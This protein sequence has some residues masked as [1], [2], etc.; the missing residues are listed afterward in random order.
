MYCP[1]C[2][3]RNGKTDSFCA[4]CGARLSGE[5]IIERADVSRAEEE[6]RSDTGSPTFVDRLMDH[7]SW[8]DDLLHGQMVVIAARWILVSAGL[9]L[10]LWNPF[11]IG[12]LRVQIALVL[13]LA[14][15]NFYL[16]AQVLTGKAIPA[17]VVLGASIADFAVI[18]L[19]VMIQG[20]FESSVYVF[21]FPA[22]L[23]FSVAFNTQVTSALTGGLIATYAAVA[24]TTFSGD[25]GAVLV[26]RLITIA[27]VA[28]CGNLYWR[29]ERDRRANASEL[30]AGAAPTDR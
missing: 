17:P 13:A 19:I 22:I 21:Y 5:R 11:A 20:G 26:T 2:N 23:A 8:A 10:A 4:A 1:N 14:V 7:G 12:E 9:L 27:G 24:A 30:A 3:E 15:G 25:D 18:S 28:L 16:H 29:I 6:R